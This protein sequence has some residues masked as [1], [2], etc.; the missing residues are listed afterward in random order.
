MKNN[1]TL[2][3]EVERIYRWLD[4]EINKH[5]ALKGRC[6]ACG[7]CCDFNS[8]EH[9]LYVTTPELLYFAQMMGKENIKQMTT[10]RCPY[11]IKSKCSVYEYR[12]SACRIFFCRADRNTQSE[13]TEAA[14]KKLKAL[15]SELKIPYRYTS[16][17]AALYSLKLNHTGQ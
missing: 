15:C 7:N 16:L 8:F 2:A 1:T 17:A 11:N 13:L 5:P 12:F 3:K 4:A 6:R 9:R 10:N 14:L